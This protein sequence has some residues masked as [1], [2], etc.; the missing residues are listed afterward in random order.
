MARRDLTGAVNFSYLAD[1]T[2]NDAALMDEVLGIF[3]QQSELWLRLLAPD[4]DADGWRDAA[5]TLKGAALGIGA[6]DLAKVCADAEA[7]RGASLGARAALLDQI[8][9]QLDLA[10]GDIAAWRHERALQSL[11][12]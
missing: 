9:F 6:Q 8:R 4:S 12:S 7:A 5:H 3:T 11:K 2:A 1:Y 10:L